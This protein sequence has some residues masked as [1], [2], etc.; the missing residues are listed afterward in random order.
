MRG[1]APVLLV[2]VA[3]CA[4]GG[5]PAQGG[6]VSGV[7]GLAGGGYQARID[8]REA[9]VAGS[10]QRRAELAAELAGLEAEHRALQDQIARQRAALSAEGALTPEADARIQAALGADPDPRDPEARAAALRQAIADAR[11]LSEQL[12]ALAS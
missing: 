3:G 5:D 4:A 12:A 11:R 8:E 9:A 7:A 10:E 6:F 2:V 1:V